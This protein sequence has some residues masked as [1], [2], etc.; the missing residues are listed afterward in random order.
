MQDLDFIHIRSRPI[1]LESQHKRFQTSDILKIKDSILKDRISF[2]LRHIEQKR[3]TI[4]FTA[5]DKSNLDDKNTNLISDSHHIM[6]DSTPPGA[7]AP[8]KRHFFQALQLW[9]LPMRERVLALHK[10]ITQ[11]GGY[12]G[13]DTIAL[14]NT[15]LEL[16]ECEPNRTVWEMDIPSHVCNKSGNLHGGAAATILDN[17]TS[18]ALITISKPGFLDGG[19]VSRTIT[20]SYLRPVPKGVRVRIECDV[21]AA[22]RNTANILGK[23]FVNGKLAVTC[24]HDKAV[25]PSNKAAAAKL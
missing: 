20:T 6:P 14:E 16:V 12:R 1:L 18:T 13:F 24:V 9:D 17:L 8:K 23:I 15:R 2:E 11:D 7:E 22:G 19:H 5:R 25:F 3:L 10:E 4:P 21:Q